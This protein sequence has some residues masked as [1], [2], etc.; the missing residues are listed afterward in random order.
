MNRYI[1]QAQ[2]LLADRVTVTGESFLVEVTAR[3]LESALETVRK[4]SSTPLQLTPL[5]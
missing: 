5:A 4:G 2:H 1:I 3:N